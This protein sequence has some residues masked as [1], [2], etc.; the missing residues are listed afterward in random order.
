MRHTKKRKTCTGMQLTI[1]KC[2]SNL[3]TS[4]WKKGT[5]KFSE[6]NVTS[7]LL[8]CVLRSDRFCCE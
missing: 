5:K 4:R 6:K 7:F 1:V 3:S 8:L 2:V